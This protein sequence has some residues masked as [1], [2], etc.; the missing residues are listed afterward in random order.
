MDKLLKVL[1]GGEWQNQLEDAFKWYK[2]IIYDL[3]AC[4]EETEVCDCLD[5]DIGL[6]V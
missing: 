2:H 5:E 1:Y 4:S 6:R 3:P